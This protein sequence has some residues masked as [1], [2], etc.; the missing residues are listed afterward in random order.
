MKENIKRL[1]KDEYVVLIILFE[2]YVTTLGRI[3]TDKL[4][5]ESLSLVVFAKV[6]M[7]QWFLGEELTAFQFTN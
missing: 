2:G 7:F 3:F 5:D 6:V 4:K 1:Q